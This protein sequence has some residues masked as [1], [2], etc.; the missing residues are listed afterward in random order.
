M[1]QANGR[2]LQTRI[3]TTPRGGACVELSLRPTSPESLTLAEFTAM[4]VQELRFR[5]VAFEQRAMIEFAASVWALAEDDP[6]VERW[7][8][9][10][11]ARPPDDG[12]TG[13][14]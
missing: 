9:D 2:K 7:A 11:I 12:V 14:A 10:F 8:R 5:G 13:P 1:H 4:L 6:D 3:L